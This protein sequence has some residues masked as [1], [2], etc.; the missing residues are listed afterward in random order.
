M[1]FIR[2][3]FTQQSHVDEKG[4][5]RFFVGFGVH[6]H[7]NKGY[8]YQHRMVMEN[9]VGRHLEPGEVVHHINEIKT[10]NRLENLFLCSPEEHAAIHNRYRKNSLEKR[11]KISKGVQKAHRGIDKSERTEG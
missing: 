10:D 4:Y 2:H 7:S 9:S 5:V 1:D 8:L 11:A 6:P 3:D